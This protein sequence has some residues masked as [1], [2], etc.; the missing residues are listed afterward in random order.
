MTVD[1][2]LAEARFVGVERLDAQQLMAHVLGRPR[3]WVLAHGDDLLDEQAQAAYRVLLRR[4]AAGEPFAYLVGERE[5]HGLMLRVTPAVL[6]PR[7]DTETLVEWALAILAGPLADR[8]SPAVLDLGTGSGAIA[9]AVKHGCAR[10]RVAALDASPAAVEVAQANGRRLGLDVEVR[11]GDWWSGVAAAS[12]DLALS[13]PPYIAE[14]D[15][16]LPSLSHEPRLALTAGGDGLAALDHL[17]RGAPARLRDGGWLLLEHGWDQ[18][19]QVRDRLLAEGFSDV[20]TRF[21]IE[22]RERCSGGRRP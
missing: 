6:V 20:S 15:P 9:L 5:F 8:P 12:V 21:D 1:G 14:D 3:S 10:A 17:I 7:P 16:H 22:G 13:N 4:R 18:G 19:P 2:A 11:V